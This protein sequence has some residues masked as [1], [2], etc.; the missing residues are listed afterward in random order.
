MSVCAAVN[1][2]F[3]PEIFGHSGLQLLHTNRRNIR[4]ILH[5]MREILQTLPK[6][7]IE[8]Y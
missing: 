4:E 5:N 8:T 7:C 6:N 1:V 3:V 2:D